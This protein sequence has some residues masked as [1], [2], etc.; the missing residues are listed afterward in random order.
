LLIQFHCALDQ[1]PERVDS[2]GSRQ[3]G[4]IQ[5]AAPNRSEAASTYAQF[6]VNRPWIR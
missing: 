1:R 6:F 2:V 3:Q 5:A 4:T